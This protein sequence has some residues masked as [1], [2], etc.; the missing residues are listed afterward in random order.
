MAHAA[1]PVTVHVI[2]AGKLRRY[3]GI[4]L[5]KQLLDIPTAVKNLRDVFYIGTGL[6]QS[7]LLL[8]RFRPEVVFA[9]GGYVC[10]PL[11]YAA[12]T[13]NI[14]VVIHDSDTRPG[15]TN[16]LLSRFAA[17]IATGSPLE[18]YS[19]PA[20]RTVYTG[21]PIDAA[22][23]PFSAA[24]QREAKQAIG[25]VDLD[26]PLIVVTGGGLGAAPIN[27]AV[28]ESAERL[29]ADGFAIYHVTGKKHID[30]VRK[31]AYEHPDYHIVD[32]VYKDMATVLGAADLVVSRASATFLQELA[33]LAK[34]VI[35]V[36]AAHLGDQ[37]KNATVYENAGA[38]YVLS[39][40]QLR[41]EDALYETIAMWRHDPAAAE[42]MI[43]RFHAFAKPDAAEH[44]ARLIVNVRSDKEDD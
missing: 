18:N 31:H 12:K 4:P 39:D 27:R 17:S 5:W 25:I 37:V 24:T 6:I 3:H 7:L 32:F 38:A 10:L 34:P 15:L 41:D 16:R 14:P 40:A 9:K 42:S 43:K 13:L 44:V 28:M 21:V 11:G 33:A 29:I 35:I 30:S 23:R 19:Y 22:F 1:I 20:E 26:K 8:R 2:A 36:P